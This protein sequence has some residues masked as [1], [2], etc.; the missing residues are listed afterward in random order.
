MQEPVLFN[1]DV[2]RNVNYGDLSKRYA[3][4]K[5]AM[6]IANISDL[7][8]PSYDQKVIPVSGG[9]K[10]RLAIARAMIREPKILLLD[11]ATSPLDKNNE[12]AVQKTLNEV[13]KGRTSVSIAHR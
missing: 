12:D 5:E 3:E 4:V 9:Q 6:K 1:Y 8:D 10:Q 13:M 7:L 2:V 11:E